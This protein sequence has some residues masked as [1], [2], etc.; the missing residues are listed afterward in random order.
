MLKGYSEIRYPKYRPYM[1]F[2]RI[3]HDSNTNLTSRVQKQSSL[4]KIY[5]NL[6]VFEF[7]M[8]EHHCIRHTVQYSM[9]RYNSFYHAYLANAIKK[10]YIANWKF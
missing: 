8:S 1:Y 7:L 10:S 9:E 6:C 3:L 4:N 2:S 5:A